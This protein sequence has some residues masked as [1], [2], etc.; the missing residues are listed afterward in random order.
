[1]V[2]TKIISIVMEEKIL[3]GQILEFPYKHD[4]F[5]LLE[6]MDIL[7]ANTVNNPKLLLHQGDC[8]FVQKLVVRNPHVFPASVKLMKIRSSQP[9]LASGQSEAMKGYWITTYLNSK[10]K[11]SDMGSSFEVMMEDWL[12]KCKPDGQTADDVPPDRDSL[13][14][15]MDSR[16]IRVNRFLRDNC[17]KSLSL[18]QLADMIQCNPVYLCNTYSKIFKISPMKKLQILKMQK[19]KMWLKD[20]DISVFEISHKLGYVSSS[21]FAELFK[22]YHG[23]SPIEFRRETRLGE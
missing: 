23:V 19:A 11:I 12:K 5:V 8:I 2:S 10:L 9:M 4:E 20:T 7:E 22:R 21:Q 1:M 6:A 13:N 15:K 18:Q 3:P 16:L 14:G 17:D